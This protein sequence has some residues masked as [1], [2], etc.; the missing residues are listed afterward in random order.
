[1]MMGRHR[2]K[3]AGIAL[4]LIGFAA[5]SFAQQPS[6]PDDVSAFVSRRDGCDHFRG[7]E[8]TDRDRRAQIE[9]ALS[10]L[11]RGSDADLAR[12]KRQYSGNKAVMT[13]LERYEPD[14]EGDGAAE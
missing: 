9:E 13:I 3:R 11:C 2:A 6:L 1:M 14:I 10:R 7:E 12:L 4:A 5:P 8:A